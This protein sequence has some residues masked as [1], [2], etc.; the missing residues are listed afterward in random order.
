VPHTTMLPAQPWSCHICHK[1]YRRV[2][3]LTRHLSSHSSHRPHTC[4]GCGKA[5]RRRDVLRRH[6]AT[7][8]TEEAVPA[9]DRPK[10]QRRRAC[11]AC[12][13]KK[14]ACD[15]GQ[16]CSSCRASCDTCSYSWKTVDCLVFTQSD[17]DSLSWQAA[18]DEQHWN[19]LNV[20][21]DAPGTPFQVYACSVSGAGNKPPDYEPE[22]SHPV[23]YALS[24][25][26]SAY[27]TDLDKNPVRSF[28][29]LLRFTSP[30]VCGIS[31]KFNGLLR[32]HRLMGPIMNVEDYNV[33]S[34][35]QVSDDIFGGA[36][37]MFPASLSCASDSLGVQT[38]INTGTAFPG[39][40]VHGNVRGGFSGTSAVGLEPLILK[41]HEILWGIRD[42]ALREAGCLRATR[43]AWSPVVEQMCVQFF[44]PARLRRHLDH[45]W[46]YWYPHWVTIHQPSFC[47]METS[48]S[49]L[50]AMA[51]IGACASPHESD[52]A[53]AHHW[54]NYVEEM[55]FAE[56]GAH[57]VSHLDGTLSIDDLRA[58]LRSLQ[59]AF[60]VCMY[61]I[62]EGT[63][64]DTDRVRQQR[65][66]IMVTFARVLMPYA[67]HRELDK[68]T[69]ETFDWQQFILTE[70]II[71]TILYVFLVDSY[72]VI[73]HGVPPKM[74][75]REL[76]LDLAAPEQCFRAP[77]A[78]SC[79][80][81]LRPWTSLPLSGDRLI[82][83]AA[84][85]SLRARRMDDPIFLHL[86]RAGHLNLWVLC[87]ALHHVIFNLEPA[88]GQESQFDALE[89]ALANWRRVWNQHLS[90]EPN[91]PP[92]VEV[93]DLET[94][95]P[96]LRLGLMRYAPEWWLLA[97]HILQRMRSS[98]ADLEASET[99][100]GPGCPRSNLAPS[101]VQGV[102]ATDTAELHDFMIRCPLLA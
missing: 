28:Q 20:D 15:T 52:R 99:L 84:I 40:R 44:H 19:Y 17:T 82:V 14:R 29:F 74:S 25:P 78:V 71:R 36:S 3:H 6:Q 13:S 94:S 5:Y 80:C 53:G 90:Q 102:D 7:C 61:Q 59:A 66:T 48:P 49:L 39:P 27:L 72:F 85:K 63:R 54:R 83:Y 88:F 98:Q 9:S 97:R 35:S 77:D 75:I 81:H 73:F 31:A 26:I 30:K 11:D 93:D 12:A 70:E 2:D 42:V 92:V 1:V 91:E 101:L 60:A 89:N 100:S 62:W 10:T 46:R 57:G 50:A 69:P 87:S 79:F 58:L 37:G 22:V 18:V 34:F 67:N 64:F 96:G 43:Q 21:L 24:P 47:A 86:A 16:P 56:L 51:V 45:F 68:V 32:T 41:S 55:A 65:Y 95:R 33:T 38:N 8:Q 4:P 76:K 23:S